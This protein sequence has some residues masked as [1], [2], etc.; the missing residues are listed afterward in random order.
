MIYDEIAA[1][2]HYVTAL[3]VFGGLLGF[4]LEGAVLGPILVCIALVATKCIHLFYDSTVQG[5]HHQGGHH[6]GGHP[7]LSRTAS[8]PPNQ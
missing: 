8:V 5:G 2:H 1:S 6:Q 7:S 3:A 4:G